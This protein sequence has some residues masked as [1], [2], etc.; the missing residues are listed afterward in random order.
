MDLKRLPVDDVLL[1]CRSWV[2]FV[3]SSLCT[4]YFE[5]LVSLYYIFCTICN[6]V[7]QLAYALWV[8]GRLSV[9][10][11][12]LGRVRGMINKWYQRDL[13][14][15][16]LNDLSTLDR[17]VKPKVLIRIWTQIESITLEMGSSH[18][19]I[20]YSHLTFRFCFQQIILT[21]SLVSIPCITL[22]YMADPLALIHLLLPMIT[23]I[24]IFLGA[25]PLCHS[26]K[27]K[28]VLVIY[29]TRDWVAWAVTTCLWKFSY[30]Q[31]K[32]YLV[33]FFILWKGDAFFLS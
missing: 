16:L 19:L 22:I 26:I 4:L 17:S 14:K 6:L 11:V 23:L 15:F 31:A 1:C 29:T 5:L 2:V 20:L 32:D 8:Y 24:L 25:I 7:T 21:L 13:G 12:L 30:F 10:Q 18:L 27:W 28:N 9:H 33:D 3:C